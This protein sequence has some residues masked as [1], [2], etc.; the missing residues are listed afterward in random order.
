MTSIDFLSGKF[1]EISKQMAE[2]KASNGPLKK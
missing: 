1:D 2:M